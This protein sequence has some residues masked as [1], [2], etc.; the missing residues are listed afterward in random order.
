MCNPDNVRSGMIIP[1]LEETIVK[2]GEQM[3]LSRQKR[4]LTLSLELQYA[5]KTISW[6]GICESLETNP[7]YQPFL[8]C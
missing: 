6:I 5:R 3:E 4:S 8:N 2:D 1:L 7:A